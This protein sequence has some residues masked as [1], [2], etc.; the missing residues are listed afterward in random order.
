MKPFVAI[1]KKVYFWTKLEFTMIPMQ[2]FI[3]KVEE[4]FED[5]EKGVLKPESVI[6]D[7]FTWDS[8][9]ALILIAHVNVEYGV[10]INAEDL[11]NAK[12]FQELYDIVDS[13]SQSS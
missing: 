2:E 12:A 3:S 4:E 9:N 11:V 10:V 5:L 7:H 8:I 1:I 6:K 13:R